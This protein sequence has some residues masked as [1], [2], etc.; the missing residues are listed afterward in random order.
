VT[1]TNTVTTTLINDAPTAVDDYKMT[2]V[3]AEYYGYQEGTDGA[4]LT[5]IDQIRN[6]MASNTPD[7]TFTPTSLNYALGTGNLGSGTN[8]QTFLGADAS[9][10]SADPANTS[11]AIIHMNGFITLSAGT[12]NFKVTADDGYTIL[13]DGNPVATVN[14]IQSP[15]G[16]VHA[17]FTVAD[18]EHSIEIIYWD[19]AGE[20][21]FKVEISNDGGSSYQVLNVSE[22]SHSFVTPED[23]PLVLASSDLLVN[24]TDPDGDQ[25][26]IVDVSNASGGTVSIDGS[27][28]VIFTPTPNYH[29]SAYFDYTISDGHGGSDVARVY[30]TVT[31]INDTT[32]IIVTDTNGNGTD[33]D[34]TVDE[35]ALSVGTDATSNAE[36]TSGSFTIVAGDGLSKITVAGTDITAAQ[37]A[38]VNTI[39]PIIVSNGIMTITGFDS[40]TGTVDYQYTVNTVTQEGSTDTTIISVAVTDID[41]STVSGQINVNIVDDSPSSAPQTINLEVKPITTNVIF[42]L[43]VSGSMDSTERKLE[44][45]AR[46]Y[47]ISEYSKIGDVNV[48]QVLFDDNAVNSGWTTS[49]AILGTSISGG[50]YTNYEAALGSVINNYSIGTPTAD[51][52]IIYFISDGDITKGSTTNWQLNW[53][54]FI[55]QDSI[56]KLFTFGVGAGITIASGSDLNAVALPTETVKSPDPIAVGSITDLSAEVGKTVGIYTEGSLIVSTNGDNIIDFG[57]DGGHIASITIGANTVYYDAVNVTQTVAGEHGDFNIN[58]ET[59]TYTYTPRDYVS[60]VEKINAS[61]VDHDGDQL[62]TILLDINVTVDSRIDT[63]TASAP[64]LV[65]SMD[66]G[67]AITAYTDSFANSLDGWSGLNVSQSNGYM[68]IDGNGNRALKTFDFGV[69]NAGK[70]VTLTFKTDISGTNWDGGSDDFR[71][72]INGVSNVYVKTNDNDLNGGVS[73]SIT[74]TLNAAG[75]AIVELFVDSDKTNEYVRIDDFSITGNTLIPFAYE[76]KLTLNAG[77]TGPTETL[78]DFTLTDLPIGITLKDASGTVIVQ[79]GDG[80]YTVSHD[81]NGDQ[82]VTIVS[83]SILDDSVSSKIT[84]SI[85]S[86]ETNGDIATTTIAGSNNDTLSYSIGDS[87]DGGTGTDTLA[88]MSGSNIDF[89]ALNSTA[90]SIKNMEVI[91]LNVNGNH[92]LT[93]LSLQDVIDMTDIN[94]TLTIIGDSADSVNVPQASGN[95]SVAKATDGGFDVYTY[96][97]NAGDPTVTVKIEQDIT[98]S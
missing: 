41:G 22:G 57:A 76:Y 44:A 3:R 25:L 87:V 7:A 73:H 91:D 59:G 8:L 38:N 15:T 89:S 60:Y 58:F 77:L 24:D 9:S 84:T 64:T 46:D 82:V 40:A 51:Q 19:Q 13:I 86:I 50:G 47:A 69:A 83:S 30:L 21:Q 16:T 63:T 92:N 34:I 96:S 81:N 78:S 37:L 43:D 67:T 61:V 1:Q 75:Q 55:A 95:Y 62:D 11:D 12:Y 54:N 14:Y 53:S 45:D 85:S 6:F 39:N 72:N 33:G 79:N 26:T 2:G 18:G 20:Y 66:A 28:N 31:S 56:T 80:S 71:V 52:T 23:T 42:V 35:G 27:G 4:N 17:P 98:H 68:S 48:M 70:T 94:N 97:S 10:L 49:S 93:N 90:N 36:T 74:T 32:T 88:L 65:V 29:G 5:S